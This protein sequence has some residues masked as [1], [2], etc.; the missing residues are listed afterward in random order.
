MNTFL[1]SNAW[2]YRVARTVFQAL[3]GFVMDWIVQIMAMTSLSGEM[4][5][6][7]V[8]LTMC[9]LSAVMKGLGDEDAEL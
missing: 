7:I 4:Q 8:A 1:T 2:Q 6:M 5:A 9:V 3:I